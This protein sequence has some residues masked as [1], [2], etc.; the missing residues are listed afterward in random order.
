MLF[1]F[2]YAVNCC[3]SIKYSKLFKLF[4]LF[5]IMNWKDEQIEHLIMFYSRNSFL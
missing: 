1:V 2:V 4:K 5:I 3:L